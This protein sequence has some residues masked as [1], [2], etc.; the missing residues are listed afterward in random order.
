MYSSQDKQKKIILSWRLA[1]T[2]NILSQIWNSLLLWVTEQKFTSWNIW[3]IGKRTKNSQCESISKSG[4]KDW[5][6]AW[7]LLACLSPSGC[8]QGQQSSVTLQKCLTG[9]LQQQHDKCRTQQRASVMMYYF[10]LTRKFRNTGIDPAVHAQPKFQ[11]TSVCNAGNLD[12]HILKKW[13]RF[14]FQEY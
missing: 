7:Q 12:P 9:R 1:Q 8:S 14:F 2:F 11:P 10:S 3:R 6:G 5:Q 4:Q 13:F